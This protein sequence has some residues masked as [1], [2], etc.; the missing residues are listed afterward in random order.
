MMALM[1]N[2]GYFSYACS[3][4][5]EQSVVV[6][7][8][9]QSKQT[10]RRYLMNGQSQALPNFREGRYG[11]ACGHFKNANEEIGN[12]LIHGLWSA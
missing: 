11:H 2:D 1:S 7:G 3:I 4:E 5:E 12:S 9:A 8:G 10:V 6:T